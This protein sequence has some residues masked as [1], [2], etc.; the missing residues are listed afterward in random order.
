MKIR[1]GST[2]QEYGLLRPAHFHGS[3]DHGSGYYYDERP[4]QNPAPP[5]EGC[6]GNVSALRLI[7]SSDWLKGSYN[8]LESQIR[9]GDE[10]KVIDP[11]CKMEIEDKW[12]AFKSEYKGNTYYFCCESCKKRFDDSPEKYIG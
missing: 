6:Y 1:P 12:A 11:A 4:S 9:G 3:S 7:L 10:M 5:Q 8:H 2:V